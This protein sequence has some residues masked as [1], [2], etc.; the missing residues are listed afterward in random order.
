MKLNNG[1]VFVFLFCL[2]GG[3][4]IPNHSAGAIDNTSL[5][6]NHS[7]LS[8][9]F[10]QLYYW[11]GQ[12]NDYQ[13]TLILE[14]ISKINDEHPIYLEA[15]LLRAIKE[16]SFD[17]AKHYLIK[18]TQ[19]NIALSCVE[20]LKNLIEVFE[21]HR[22]TLA[23]ARILAKSHQYEQS[24]KK[25]QSV[26]NTEN[27][28]PMLALEYWDV[29]SLVHP[30]TEPLI[31]RKL[32]QLTHQEPTNNLYRVAFLKYLIHSQN[33]STDVFEQLEKLTLDPIWQAEAKRIWA[34]ALEKMPISDNNQSLF[35]RYLTHFPED[36]FVRFHYENGL[37]ALNKHKQLI[38]IPQYQAK[39][40][41]LKL[42]EEQGNT[43]IIKQKLNFAL[44]YFKQD[45]ELISGLGKV[46]LREADYE[47]A[48]QF[49]L[50]CLSIDK[51][52]RTCSSLLKTA[53]YWHKISLAKN[54]IK[55]NQWDDAYSILVSLSNQSEQE[56]VSHLVLIG[57]Y[58]FAKAQFDNAEQYYSRA[59][60]ID[61]KNGSA[62]RGLLQ[63]REH[64]GEAAFERWLTTLSTE[65]FNLIK[66]DII[67]AKIKFIRQRADLLVSQG[68]YEEAISLLGEA[69]ALDRSNAWVRFDI[70]K[71]YIEQNKTDNIR[72]LFRTIDNEESAFAYALLL[73]N[74]DD[75]EQAIK[76]L[77]LVNESKRSKAMHEALQRF[78][79]GYL[80]QTLASMQSLDEKQKLLQDFPLHKL[81]LPK[82]RFDTAVLLFEQGLYQ[83]SLSILNLLYKDDLIEQN[84]YQLLSVKI[85]QQL[86]QYKQAE[87]LLIQLLV[88]PHLTQKQQSELVDLIVNQYQ[89][90]NNTLVNIGWIRDY[91]DQLLAE[92]S[93]SWDAWLLKRQYFQLTKDWKSEFELLTQAVHSFPDRIDIHKM[94]LNFYL[95]HITQLEESE[96]YDFYNE[97]VLPFIAKYPFELDGYK[98]ASQFATRYGDTRLKQ[99]YLK[100]ALNIALIS[101]KL[102]LLGVDVTSFENYEQFKLW[103]NNQQKY[104]SNNSTYNELRAI[105]ASD[106]NIIAL[107]EQ[108]ERWEVK[109]L[110][111]QLLSDNEQTNTIF[112]IGFRGY[113][114]SGTKGQSQYSLNVMPMSL[115]MP[116]NKKW[117][118]TNGRWFVRFEPTKIDAGSVSP[119]DENYDE[120]GALKLCDTPC[121]FEEQNQSQLGYS[122]AVGASLER[123][124]FDIGTTPIGFNKFDWVGGV[125]YEGKI[126]DIGW[127]GFMTKR[128]VTNSVLSY[129]GSYDPYSRLFWG[130]AKIYTLGS[131]FSY[132]QGE[133]WGLWSVFDYSKIK[134][135]ETKDN[136]RLRAMLGIYYTWFDSEK[137]TSTIGI[138]SLNWQ[139]QYDLSEFTLGQSGYYSPQ[140]YSSISI[141]FDV[142]GRINDFSYKIYLGL[143]ISK[144][145]DQTIDF[146]PLHKKYQKILIE[147]NQQNLLSTQFQ[148]GSGTGIGYSIAADIEYKINQHWSIGASLDLQQYE[149][150]SPNTMSIYLRYYFDRSYLPVYKPPKP[151]KAYLDF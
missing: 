33:F 63:L 37:A 145:S 39:L 102:Q 151:L 60:R 109:S 38:K 22:E 46:F 8:Y 118:D 74:M 119:T 27:I 51:T 98:V 147:K 70:G 85:L 82:F 83:E 3:F 61:P 150:F 71:I 91:S 92:N 141:P 134:G 49:F 2:L 53:R 140:R 18:L 117:F 112:E 52:N 5:N 43:Q 93:K 7:D 142:Y 108:S 72:Y 126:R 136:N 84:K 135:E 65:Q 12:Q 96:A 73:A 111:N 115:S 62:L 32:T 100:Q 13:E 131:S 138:N 34:T 16:N 78:Y 68:R 24:L 4:L 130:A 81:K 54:L 14:K 89:Y 50:K 36:N 56:G 31:L 79:V 76:Q 146:F 103:I 87:K 9:L 17:E 11:R 97:F 66:E 94:A 64:S 35:T 28:H 128:P 40:T 75:Y 132:D 148:G 149:Y 88:R 26:L 123:W 104:D 90:D 116:I 106:S 101:E 143:S 15:L 124:H 107:S 122:F 41:G 105:L 69:L 144:S 23:Q 120:F 86:K 47:K 77:E 125:E 139:Y 10:E 48:E 45:V 42:L 57:D 137:L 29:L 21:K 30:E 19:T 58:H 55:N 20:A 129:A 25:Y 44:S 114:K 80:K 95:E 110:R 127:S 6:N 67:S 113:S 121:E 99:R 1:T 133:G 59:L